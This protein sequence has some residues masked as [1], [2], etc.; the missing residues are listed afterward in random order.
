MENCYNVKYSKLEGE[1]HWTNDM[2]G[3]VF[4]C[5]HG[6]Y[7]TKTNNIYNYPTKQKTNTPA[8]QLSSCQTTNADRPRE[9]H[10]TSFGSMRS[11]KR[12]KMFVYTTINP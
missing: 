6:G 4:L 9:G 3:S 12:Y 8:S 11:R 1:I 2:P 5:V 10:L 7:A